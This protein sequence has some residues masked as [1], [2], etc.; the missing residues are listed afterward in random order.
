M[1]DRFH[2]L[3]PLA[4]PYERNG[5]MHCHRRRRRLPFR[6]LYEYTYTRINISSVEARTPHGRVPCVRLRCSSVLE[7]PLANTSAL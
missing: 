5:A 1:S 2:P 7:H 3:R 6:V 4:R